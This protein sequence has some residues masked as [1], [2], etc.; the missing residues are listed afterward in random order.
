MSRSVVLHPVVANFV[1]PSTTPEGLLEV[2]ENDAVLLFSE[3]CDSDFPVSRPVISIRSP[4]LHEY[5]T[6]PFMQCQA[7]FLFLF[8]RGLWIRWGNLIG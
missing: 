3:G 1:L 8:H 2:L 6:R 5:I 7:L 4:Q